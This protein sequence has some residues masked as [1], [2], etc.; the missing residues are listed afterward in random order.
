MVLIIAGILETIFPLTTILF[1]VPKL[2][3]LYSQ[4]TITGYNPTLLYGLF[5]LIMII[6]ISQIVYGIMMGNIQ[7]KTGELTNSQKNIAKILFLIGT[8]MAFLAIPIMVLTIILPIYR[9]TTF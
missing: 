5:G 2:V 9:L 1:V 8:V 6:S 7:R 4:S 3:S